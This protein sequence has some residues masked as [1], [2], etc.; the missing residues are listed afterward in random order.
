MASEYERRIRSFL[1]SDNLPT[2]T[3]ALKLLGD[4]R[5]DRALSKTQVEQLEA[6]FAD[7]A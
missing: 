1:E 4:A 6:L 5:R 3:M 2:R 7:G